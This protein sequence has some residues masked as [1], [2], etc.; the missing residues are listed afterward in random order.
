MCPGCARSRIHP[1]EHLAVFLLQKL[2]MQ[3]SGCQLDRHE[4]LNY[5]WLWLGIV[6]DE[7]AR[8]WQE[9]ATKEK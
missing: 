1:Q 5:E 9:E 2:Q 4:L 8:V 3:D 6:K 7:R